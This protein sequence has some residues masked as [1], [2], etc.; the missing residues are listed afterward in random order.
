MDLEFVEFVGK[1][2]RVEQAFIGNDRA[3]LH[4]LL[5]EL[6]P[7]ARDRRRA[8]ALIDF[9]LGDTGMPVFRSKSVAPFLESIAVTKAALASCHPVPA[10]RCSHRVIG[11]DLDFLGDTEGFWSWTIAQCVNYLLIN[12]LQPSRKAAVVGTMRDDGIYIV[13]W[14]AYYLALGF[15][16]IFIYTNDNSDGSEVLLRLLVDHDVISLIESETSG[17]VPPEVKAYE[18]AVQLLHDL[19]DFEWVMFVDSDEFFVPASCYNYSISE[20]LAALEKRFPGQLPSGICYHWLWLVSGNAFARDRG[21]LIERFQHA[22][23]HF[24]TKVLVRIRDLISMRHQHFPEVKEGRSL[25]N[26]AFAPIPTDLESFAQILDEKRQEYAGGWVNHYWVRSFEEFAVKKARGK[27]L[28]LEDN[29]YDRDFRLFFLWNGEE[30]PENHYP[31]DTAWLGRVKAKI[32]QLKKL[33]GVGALAE[34]IDRDFPLL[35]KHHYGR[36]S[37]RAMYRKYRTEPGEL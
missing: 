10:P 19:R 31:I 21:L 8:P 22:R 36:R 37:L 12:R 5:V 25:V 18:H 16:H 26:S 6:L 28:Q 23:P 13:E 17:T 34:K 1:L 29:T 24:Y 11:A 20:I 30:T 2:A 27:S 35:L 33:E 3:R 15:D 14:V 9:A 4:Q 7:K 32:E